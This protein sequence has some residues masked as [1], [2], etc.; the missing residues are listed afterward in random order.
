RA[1]KVADGLSLEEALEEIKRAVENGHDINFCVDG[2]TALDLL[3]R[4]LEGGDPI[5]V[6]EKMEEFLN[7]MDSKGAKTQE[8]VQAAPSRF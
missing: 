8:Q 7:W 6:N 3:R 4:R 2:E 1:N 5:L